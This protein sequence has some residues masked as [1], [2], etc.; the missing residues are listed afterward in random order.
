MNDGRRADR[1]AESNI[2]DIRLVLVRSAPYMIENPKPTYDIVGQ[3]YNV[4]INLLT[5]FIKL[6]P[7]RCMAQ[8]I[9]DGFAS[10]TNVIK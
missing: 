9:N 10:K 8:T 4:I 2:R 6:T 5:K 7:N 1:R 3:I